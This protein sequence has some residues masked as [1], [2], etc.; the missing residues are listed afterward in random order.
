M[1]HV[2]EKYS[3]V[4]EVQ[5]L[6]PQKFNNTAVRKNWVTLLVSN[7]DTFEVQVLEQHKFNNTVVSKIYVTL[8][9]SPT[10]TCE[11]Q[12]LVQHKFTIR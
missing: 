3:Y 8:L 4:C 5:A 1:K 12:V 11:V 7:T 10:A 9:D 6:V 2:Q